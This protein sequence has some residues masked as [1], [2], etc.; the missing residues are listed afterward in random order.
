LGVHWGYER[1]RGH[2]QFIADPVDSRS[3]GDVH[4]DDHLADGKG[5]KGTE[6]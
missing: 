1:G 6:Q 2:D 4:R 3:G 5:G